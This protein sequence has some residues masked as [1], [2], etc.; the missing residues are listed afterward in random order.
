MD[1]ATP[2]A[3]ALDDI[4]ALRGALADAEA[5][6]CAAQAEAARAVAQASSADALIASLKLEIEK[7]RRELYGTRSERKARLLDQLE[8]QL[9]DLEATAGEDAQAGTRTTPG[10]AFTPKTPA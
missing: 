6:A 10:K 7:L 3:S 1:A 9:E 4:A 5:R 8:L 2:A